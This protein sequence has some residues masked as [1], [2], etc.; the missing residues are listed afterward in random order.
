M[1]NA[2]RGIGKAALYAGLAGAMVVSILP[3]AGVSS[4]AAQGNSR[5][6]NNFKVD[7]RF[8][9]VWSSQGSEQN[10]VFVNGLPITNRRPEIS[11]VDG[12]TYETQWFERARYELHTENKAPYDVLL[13]LLGNLLTEG[14]RSIDPATGKARNASDQPFVGIDKPGDANGKDKVWFPETKHSISGEILNTWNK[15]G[16]LQQFGFPISEQFKEVSATDGKTYDV[17]YFER[18]RFELH[19]EKQAPYNVE[20]G[21]LG[22]QQYKTTP[23]PADQ[24]PFAPPKD[25]K[26]SKDT[27]ISGTQQFPTSLVDFEEG[28]VVAQRF[29]DPITLGEGLVHGDEKENY[30]PTAAWYV[31]TLEN[32]GSFYVGTGNDR[33]LVTKYKL[34]PGIKWADGKEITSK[35]AIFAYNFLLADPNVVSTQQLKKL[36]NVDNPDKYTIV[37]NWMSLNQAQAK[38]NDPK[39]DKEDFAFLSLYINNKQPVLDKVYFLVGTILPE[40]VLGKIPPEKVQESSYARNPMG[41]GPYKVAEFKENDT[42]TLVANENYNL[43]APPLIK[44]I[45]SKYF[46]DINQNVAQ[47]VTGN[48]D[49]IAGD[50]TV[51]PPEQSPQI[52]AA[53]GV[54]DSQPASAWEHLEPYF[55]YAPFQDHAVREAMITAINRKQIADVV[56]K[57]AAAVMNSPVPP[58]IYFSLDNPDFAKNFPELAQKYKLPIYNYD[59]AKANKLLDDAGWVKGSDGIRAKNGVKLSFE[60]ATTKNTTRQSI[61]A[62]VQNDLKTVGIDAMVTNYPQGFFSPT[63]PRATGKTKLAEFA[64]V[65]T[66]DS[67]FDPYS[68]DELWTPSDTGKQNV[69]QYKNAKV[70]EANRTFNAVI[71]RQETAEAAAIAQVEMMQDIAVIPLVQRANIEIYKQSL[72]NRKVTN[73]SISQWWNLQQWYF[74]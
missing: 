7:G 12:K 45:V 10:S 46:T 9:E 44:R 57:G 61:Q 3:A 62:L 30:F 4:V 56:F 67:G 2:K 41:Y 31:P 13:G 71:G 17:Q 49:A 14:R 18:N 47:F 60:Y 73:S 1:N 24:L 72:Q 32:G 23:V 25:V 28:T 58:S 34:R 74:K 50:G 11:V 6:I 48:L 52:K 53:N 69:Q 43:T 70:T 5:T 16:G 15:F 22:V 40:Q 27:L 51:V 29:T 38:F 55:G 42:V 26:S 39:T 19:P 63:G 65:Q 8:L 59:P 68:T 36:F 20:L 64:Y 66:T 21:L 37:Y 35:D 33:H 54:I